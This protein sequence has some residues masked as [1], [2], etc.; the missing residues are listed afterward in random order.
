S[1]GC[2]PACGGTAES[3]AEPAGGG[4]DD[5]RLPAS[6]GRSAAINCALRDAAFAAVGNNGLL[7]GFPGGYAADQVGGVGDLVQSENT[8]SNRR[9]IAGGTMD[10]HLPALRDFV[11]PFR[12]LAQRDVDAAF[13]VFG[14]PLTLASYIENNR[15][16][17]RGQLFSQ[18]RGSYT[19]GASDQVWM[20]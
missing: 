6:P 19:L 11:Q 1:E 8:G 18:L 7:G 10:D 9:A 17:L 20:C 5:R 4:A 16:F 12:Q 13:Y 2:G 14:L 15:R 3:Q